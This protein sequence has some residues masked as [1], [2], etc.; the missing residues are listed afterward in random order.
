[1][2]NIIL[3][4]SFSSCL[5]VAAQQAPATEE[6]KVLKTV[7]QFF[8]ALEKQD[9]ALYK[10][11]LFP[12]AQVW[13]VQLKNDS[14]KHSSWYAAEAIK[15]LVNPARIIQEKIISYEIKVHQHIAMAWAPYTLSVSGNFSHCGIDVFILF[16]TADGWKINNCSFT[17]EPEGCAA[18]EEEHKRKQAL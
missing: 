15:G 3:F 13:A 14:V 16:K 7:Q 2:K 11:V 5:S 10:S 17:V 8:E 4:F 1:M 12:E 6:Q 9:T 18:L